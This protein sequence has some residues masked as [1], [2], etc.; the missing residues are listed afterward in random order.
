M[1][2]NKV[3]I[4]LLLKLH[5]ILT[6]SALLTIYKSFIRLHLDYADI[7]YDQAY[8]VSFNQKL[9]IL[10]YNVCLA[11]TGAIRG[12]LREKLYEEL[13]LGSLQLR[14]WFRKLSCFC[15]LFNSERLHYLFKLIPLRSCNYV[16]RNIH[17]TSFLK[18]RHTLSSRQRLL[19]G[20][21][22]IIT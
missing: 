10:Q 7:T 16:T 6:K 1:T 19:N 9:E 13:N 8:N 17:D 5:N 15:K 3:T 4:E 21:N 20:I 18:T 14:R 2:L 12:T 11:I 22:L